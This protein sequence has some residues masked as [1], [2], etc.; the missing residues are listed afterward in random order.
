[1]Y[2]L[3]GLHL[4]ESKDTWGPECIFKTSQLYSLRIPRCKDSL[5]SISFYRSQFSS[6]VQVRE[7]TLRS[8]SYVS[9]SK[10]ENSVGSLWTSLHHGISVSKEIFLCQQLLH[11]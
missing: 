6:L 11:L 4:Q 1:M 9:I 8:M 2:F 3:H 5:F 10:G 7:V